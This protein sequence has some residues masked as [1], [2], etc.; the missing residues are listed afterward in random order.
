VGEGGDGGDAVLL[1]KLE[2][3]EVQLA[4]L[5]KDVE[6]EKVGRIKAET[7]LKSALSEGLVGELQSKLQKEELARKEAEAQ[8]EVS[9]ELTMLLSEARKK[10]AVADKE[11][12]KD[13]A[14]LQERIN[15]QLD[16]A[17][18]A[19]LAVTFPVIDSSAAVSPGRRRASIEASGGLGLDVEYSI[20][21]QGVFVKSVAA[22]G[23]ARHSGVR[24]GMQ[25]AAVGDIQ[26][27]GGAAAADNESKGNSPA[28]SPKDETRPAIFLK[29]VGL[30]RE[31]CGQPEKPLT[32]KV[33]ALPRHVP[34]SSHMRLA[35]IT[36]LASPHF[37]LSSTA[38]AI[39][40]P[41][42]THSAPPLGPLGPSDRQLLTTS[43]LV[44]AHQVLASTMVHRLSAKGATCLPRSRV[45]R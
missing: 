29:T 42:L 7:D 19:V 22:D 4:A 40:T 23:I 2:L 28:A 43:A 5:V 21:R 25:I 34:S 39:A 41:P 31:R 30:I 20:E 6:A 37:S 45:G 10:A 16:D 32:I 3:L 27:V 44:S 9:G 1:E 36:S 35:V 17:N 26:I 14:A 13:R 15:R 12:A 24:A 8:V 38:M 33:C 11:A 18:V